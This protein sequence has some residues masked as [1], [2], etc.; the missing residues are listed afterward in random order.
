MR[1]GHIKKRNAGGR[2]QNE[3]GLRR[4]YNS[5]A[6]WPGMG[7]G[8]P[9]PRG[10]RYKTNYT[11][12][13]EGDLAAGSGGVPSARKG[14]LLKV[15]KYR[16]VLS[17]NY[18]KI[19]RMRLTSFSQFWTHVLLL[20]ISVRASFNVPLRAVRA[21]TI[22]IDPPPQPPPFF[23]PEAAHLTS[24]RWAALGA[25]PAPPR[26]ANHP[27]AVWDR[28]VERLAERARATIITWRTWTVPGDTKKFLMW[29]R[30]GRWRLCT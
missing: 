4:T 27:P 11:S 6:A 5:M 21:L 22:S 26:H 3:L 13:W 23:S 19:N 9:S 25:H 1:V 7:L 10:S 29:A 17:G 24:H 20:V 2:R 12:T 8:G 18:R 28:E 14:L 16:T 15:R 30:V